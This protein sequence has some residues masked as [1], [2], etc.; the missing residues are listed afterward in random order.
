MSVLL[1]VMIIIATGVL[2]LVG[3]NLYLLLWIKCILKST[4]TG[5]LGTTKNFG[6]VSV[7]DFSCSRKCLK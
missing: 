6:A 4:E 7:L 1:I 2:K 5:S 3:T